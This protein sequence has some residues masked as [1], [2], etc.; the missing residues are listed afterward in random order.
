MKSK[1]DSLPCRHAGNRPEI[2]TLSLRAKSRS[3]I[4]QQKNNAPQLSYILQLWLRNTK[5]RKS[6]Y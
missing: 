6:F 3:D 1:T 2:K 5:S 4:H